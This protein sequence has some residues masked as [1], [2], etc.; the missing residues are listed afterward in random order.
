[1][2]ALITGAGVM[3]IVLVALT[4]LHVPLPVVVKVSITPWALV[5]AA[6][7]V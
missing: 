6:E 2:P 7:G 5:S 4:A 3:V 1:M